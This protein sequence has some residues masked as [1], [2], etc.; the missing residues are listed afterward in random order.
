METLANYSEVISAFIGVILGWLIGT[1][2]TL[3]VRRRE[4]RREK[5]REVMERMTKPAP[6]AASTGGQTQL[7]M[8][9]LTN[10]MMAAIAAKINKGK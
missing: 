2:I 4:K 6:M 1:G 8:V 10:A 9:A 7:D 3:L 5:V